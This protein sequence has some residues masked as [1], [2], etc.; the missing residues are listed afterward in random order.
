LTKPCLA[1]DDISQLG[2]SNE[3]HCRIIALKLVALL[4][5]SRPDVTVSVANYRVPAAASDLKS[6][7]GEA[8]YPRLPPPVVSPVNRS[9]IEGVFIKSK[10]HLFPYLTK[11]TRFIS[12]SSE[13][14][15]WCEISLNGGQG[16]EIGC[17]AWAAVEGVARVGLWN[18]LFGV[19]IL[20]PGVRG[21]VTVLW[22]KSEIERGEVVAAIDSLIQRK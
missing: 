6:Q 12:I 5:K 16:K 19:K 4:P 9:V 15:K 10:S 8:I 18:G 7:D 20:H 22:C 14:L 3:Q 17:V 1:A 21:N 11:T 2:I 13:G